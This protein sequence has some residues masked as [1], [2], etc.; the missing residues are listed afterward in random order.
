MPAPDSA[1]IST[2]LAAENSRMR[3]SFLSMWSVNKGGLLWQRTNRQ[4]DDG[5]FLSFLRSIAEG[6]ET[7]TVESLWLV[8]SFFAWQIAVV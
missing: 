6:A 1:S 2:A 5:R 7:I 4:I 8:F 3:A